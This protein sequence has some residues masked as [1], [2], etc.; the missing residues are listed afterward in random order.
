MKP[1]F[2]IVEDNPD[3]HAYIKT[4]LAIGRARQS[5]E[6]LIIKNELI[7][8]I[9]PQ[10][11]SDA[12]EKE[13]YEITYNDYSKFLEKLPEGISDQE[14]EPLNVILVL[15]LNLR[16]HEMDYVKIMKDNLKHISL[17]V[18]MMTSK[19]GHTFVKEDFDSN[20]FHSFSEYLENL[21]YK[22]TLYSYLGGFSLALKVLQN[23]KISN[24]LIGIV[25]SHTSSP[26]NVKEYF[27]KNLEL[28]HR[29]QDNTQVFIS[30][31]VWPQNAKDLIKQLVNKYNEAFGGIKH[32]IERFIESMR[33]ITEE[34][35]H[36][37]DSPLIKNLSNLL[38][39]SP[40]TDLFSTLFDLNNEDFHE[41]LNIINECLKSF[42]TRRNRGYNNRLSILGIV[43]ICWS[44]FRQQRYDLPCNL[45]EEAERKYFVGVVK[46]IIVAYEKLRKKSCENGILDASDLEYHEKLLF[47]SRYGN[48]LPDIES[49][50]NSSKGSI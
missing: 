18:E 50:D 4:I 9:I 14:I 37:S 1:L 26:E 42:S 20:N 2:L 7:K 10:E 12:G 44:I 15:D 24:V 8:R 19:E 32:P 34:E 6:H 40:S 28:F 5:G 33:K 3:P 23:K 16:L 45:I 49:F 47:L 29:T 21:N 43:L 13:D 48:V 17:F 46:K 35:A 25:S 41:D 31:L 30:D 27:D 39:F 11:K 38:N 22:N 36:H